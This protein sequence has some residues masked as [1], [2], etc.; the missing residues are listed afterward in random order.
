MTKECVIKYT[1]DKCK[2][3]YD[4]E[5]EALKCEASH[6]D[7]LYIDGQSER[8]ECRSGESAFGS[9]PKILLVRMSNGFKVPYKLANTGESQHYKMSS[10]SRHENKYF[11]ELRGF[12]PKEQYP[13]YPGMIPISYSYRNRQ[14]RLIAQLIATMAYSNFNDDEMIRV[15]KYSMVL[16]DAE[17]HQLNWKQARE[18]CGIKELLDKYLY[19]KSVKEVKPE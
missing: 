17:K 7:P 5:S 9:F 18:D 16:L 10:S 2:Q 11:Y 19:K 14:L 12:E 8:Y 6:H 3:S 15:I 4:S 1:C 13:G